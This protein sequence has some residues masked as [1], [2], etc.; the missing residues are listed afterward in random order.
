[1]DLEAIVT[2]VKAQ[3]E[4]SGNGGW[5]SSDNDKTY[6]TDRGATQPACGG[7]N[8]ATMSAPTWDATPTKV[9]D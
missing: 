6:T 8:Y 4:P 1:M 3:A 2:T 5:E 9:Q 7:A